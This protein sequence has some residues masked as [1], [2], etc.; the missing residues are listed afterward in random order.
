MRT[1]QLHEL[2]DALDADLATLVKLPE[3]RRLEMS[4]TAAGLGELLNGLRARQAS[5]ESAVRKFRYAWLMSVL[6]HVSLADVVVGAFTAEKHEKAVEEFKQGDHYHIETVPARVRRKAA[7]AAVAALDEFKE[8]AALVQHQAALRRRHMPVRD[9]VRNAA[10]VLLALKP[11]WA[12]SPLMV[13]QLLPPKPYFDVVVFDEA[14]QVQPADAV[15]A[16]LRGKQLV[17]A[18]DEKQLPPTAFFVSGGAE[19]DEQATDE[20]GPLMAGTKGFESIL[21][22][23]SPLVRFR[24]L[25]WHYRSRDERLI[26]FSNAHFYDRMLTTFAGVGGDQVLRYVPVP[27]DPSAETNS[28]TPEVNGVVDL[29]LEHAHERPQESLGVIAMGMKHAQ[30][31]EERLRQRLRAEPELE[32]RLGQFFDESRE[33]RFFVKNLETVQGDERDAVILSIGYGKNARGDLVYRS[34]HF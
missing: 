19:E 27:H 16:I 21:D 12:M 17:I 11:C 20:T 8:Q 15:P 26:A 32:G 7:E 6:E 28:P 13:S 5:E 22:A 4:L 2:L 25:Q 29:I 3:L 18:G 9:F 1:T 31:V 14:S 33:E 23:L 34:G 24:V 30:R 10:D